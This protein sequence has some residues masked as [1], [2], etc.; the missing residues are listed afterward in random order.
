MA[1]VIISVLPGFFEYWR[2]RRVASKKKKDSETQEK[3]DKTTF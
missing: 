2:Q 3:I 1:I